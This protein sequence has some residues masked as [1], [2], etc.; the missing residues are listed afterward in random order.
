M[1]GER[2]FRIGGMRRAEIDF[3]RTRGHPG[4]ANAVALEFIPGEGE[5]GSLPIFL[6]R[7]EIAHGN[8]NSFD[9]NYSHNLQPFSEASVSYIETPRSGITT[10]ERMEVLYLPRFSNDNRRS[11]VYV[12]VVTSCSIV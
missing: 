9:T 6:R 4:D 3:H 2:R 1:S 7:R 8:Q 11:N 12:R 5:S 10:G